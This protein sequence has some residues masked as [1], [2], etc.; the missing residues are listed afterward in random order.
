MKQHF[1][2]EK[3][4]IRY[5][6]RTPQHGYSL[7]SC[8]LRDQEISSYDFE[9]KE[10]NLLLNYKKVCFQNMH[11]NEIDEQKNFESF[12]KQQEFRGMQQS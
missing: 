5:P 12:A 1:T 7:I 6:L 2:H 3:G 4:I 8:E 10:I 9:M 11:L